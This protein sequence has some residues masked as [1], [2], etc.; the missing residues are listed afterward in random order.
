MRRADKLLT[1]LVELVETARAV[2]MSGSCVVPRE[3]TLDLLDDLREVLPAEMGEARRIVAERDAVLAEASAKSAELHAAAAG[4]AAELLADAR[5]ESARLVSDEAIQRSA[6]EDASALRQAV[7]TAAAATRDAAEREAAE[8][9]A[10]ATAQAG[11]L[12]EE[13][14]EWSKR[15]LGELIDTL[16]HAV[17]VAERG[18]SALTDRPS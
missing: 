16:N 1:E 7:E 13:A 4:Q 2:P 5:A 14:Q 18:R 6:T 10:T 3:H 15:T 12:R 17:G 9:V 11:V 8:I